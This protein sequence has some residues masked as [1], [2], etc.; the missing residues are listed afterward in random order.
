[1]A[2]AQ[3]T[4]E[5]LGAGRDLHQ[6][7]AR[8]QARR[9]RRRHAH[10]VRRQPAARVHGEG[11]REGPR[12]HRQ[13]RSAA[14]Q[15][16]CCRLNRAQEL[17]RRAGR[18]RLRSPSRTT[19]A[20]A[21]GCRSSDNVTRDQRSTLQCSAAQRMEGDDTKQT[22]VDDAPTAAS[23]LTTFF[24]I[25]GL[26]SIASGMLLIFLI[27]VMLAAERKVEMGMIRARRH[28]APPPDADR[29]CP[30]A[31]RTTRSPPLSAALSASPSRCHGADHGGALQRRSTSRS[32]S[33]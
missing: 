2:A 13:R 16:L 23:F 3:L 12:A 24:V 17:L 7:V 11:H 30:R 8:R 22:L 20:C 31:W 32:S 19:A 14:E 33:T 18:S 28:Q 21:T 5:T 1:M 27:F 15:G 10:G 26:F 25:L 29:S 9:P 4:L 6:R